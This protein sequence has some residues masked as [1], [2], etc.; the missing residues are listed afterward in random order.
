MTDQ[1]TL[2]TIT[3][4]LTTAYRAEAAGNLGRARVCARRAAGWAIQAHLE[5][6][7]GHPVTSNALD[8]IKYLRHPSDLPA[9]QSKRG[10]PASDLAGGQDSDDEDSLLPLGGS[11]SDCRGAVAGG[12][13]AGSEVESGEG[14]KDNILGIFI[15]LIP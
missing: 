15:R 12:G 2:K 3:T 6:R 14:V 5:A 4:E 9:T 1:Q 7:G 13:T 10:A 8:N 11:R